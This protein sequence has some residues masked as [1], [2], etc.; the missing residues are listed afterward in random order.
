MHITTTDGADVTQGIGSG[1][2]EGLSAAQKSAM[3]TEINLLEGQPFDDEL[4]R[5]RGISDEHAA[6]LLAGINAL[7]RKPG[8]LGLD[9]QHRLVWPADLLG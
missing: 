2:E 6:E 7:P 5:R 3:I 1:F 9:L 4:R 8:W